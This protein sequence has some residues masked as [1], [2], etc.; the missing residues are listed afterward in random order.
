MVLPH[1][2]GNLVWKQIIGLVNELLR[3]GVINSIRGS[4]INSPVENNPGWTT[5]K[6]IKIQAT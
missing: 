1:P 2:L 5:I 6:A 4:L 3:K